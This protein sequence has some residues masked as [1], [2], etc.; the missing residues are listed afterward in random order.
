MKLL[1]GLG[2]QLVGRLLCFDALR[3]RFTEF[4]LAPNP[5]CA[6]CGEGRPF[7]GYVDYAEFCRGVAA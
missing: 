6:H 3:A 2:D 4:E 5:D 7:P 1:L